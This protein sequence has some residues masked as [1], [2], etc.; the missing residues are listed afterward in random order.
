MDDLYVLHCES[1]LNIARKLVVLQYQYDQT[2]EIIQDGVVKLVLHKSKYKGF[3]SSCNSLT[4]GICYSFR[5]DELCKMPHPYKL[6]ADTMKIIPY[7]FS[8]ADIVTDIYGIE[9]IIL[10]N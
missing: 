8:K 10:Y 3:K 2:E 9:R 6:M 5:T 4:K 7:V 1:L